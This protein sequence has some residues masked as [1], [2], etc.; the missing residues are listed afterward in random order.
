LVNKPAKVSGSREAHT[1]TLHSMIHDAEAWYFPLGRLL[2]AASGLTLLTNDPA[3]S[4]PVSTAFNYVEKEYRIK[5]QRQ[6]KKTELTA[7][8]KALKELNAGNSDVAKVEVVQKNTRNCWI[9]F[10]LYHGSFAELFAILKNLKLEPLSMQ[11]YRIGAL[12]ADSLTPGSWK[13]LN[14]VEIA[15]MFG[16]TT[17]GA[18]FFFK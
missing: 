10:T 5:V 12:N 8:T 6:V 4:A 14:N 7:M 17:E 1:F 3:H 16:T 9:A 18:S 13:Q 15:Q 11:R 2:K